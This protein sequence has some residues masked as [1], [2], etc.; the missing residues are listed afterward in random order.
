MPKK[1]FIGYFS[2]LRFCFLFFFLHPAG[3]GAGGRPNRPPGW[4]QKAGPWKGPEGKRNGRQ[5]DNYRITKALYYYYYWPLMKQIWRLFN[6]IPIHSGS[7]SIKRGIHMGARALCLL[8]VRSPRPFL[9][10]A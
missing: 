8:F 2:T 7:E 5:G 4:E 9:R 10:E 3:F 1:N 6:T